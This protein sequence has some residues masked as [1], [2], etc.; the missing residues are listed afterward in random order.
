MELISNELQIYFKLIG[1][2]LNEK[3]KILALIKIHSRTILLM[4]IFKSK[5]S[6]KKAKK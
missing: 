1:F 6:K 5:I 3:N 2:A 4:N